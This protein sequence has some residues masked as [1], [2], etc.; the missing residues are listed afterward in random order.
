[1]AESLKDIQPYHIMII[2]VNQ[3]D[4]I[5]KSYRLEVQLDRRPDGK[6]QAGTMA[7]FEEQTALISHSKLACLGFERYAKK[8][9]TQYFRR[10]TIT[11]HFDWGIDILTKK[12]VAKIP[13]VF[14]NLVYQKATAEM[15]FT[16]DS[17]GHPQPVLSNF[18]TQTSV[19]VKEIHVR[20]S[21]HYKLSGTQYLMNVDLH[22]DLTHTSPNPGSCGINLYCLDWDSR[23]GQKDGLGCQMVEL[24]S[25]LEKLFPRADSQNGFVH[26]LQLVRDTQQFLCAADIVAAGEDL[27]ALGIPER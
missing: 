3:C 21:L 15:E 19:E 12:M 22:R 10:L 7:C 18:S 25:N 14:Q 11:R 13:K 26:F 4:N 1:M 23:L 24:G 2:I 8:N 16:T 5:P 27:E 6:Y 9:Q 20:T 17:F